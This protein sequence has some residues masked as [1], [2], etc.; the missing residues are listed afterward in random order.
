MHFIYKSNEGMIEVNKSYKIIIKRYE[1]T[2][3]PELGWQLSH[4]R[5]RWPNGADVVLKHL[6]GGAKV[7]RFPAASVCIPNLG[8]IRNS[9][10]LSL[11]RGCD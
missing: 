3:T 8:K 4:Q 9:K 2:V 10:L 5:I 6:F 7:V 11:D 1:K